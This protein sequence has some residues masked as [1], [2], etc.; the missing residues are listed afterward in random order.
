MFGYALHRCSVHLLSDRVKHSVWNCPTERS[1]GMCEL[2]FEQ[3]CIQEFI[4]H[5]VFNVDEW[6]FP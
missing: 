3:V 5:C 4:N 2:P 6:S 1:P